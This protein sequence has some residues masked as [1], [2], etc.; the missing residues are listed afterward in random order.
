MHALAISYFKRYKMEIDLP[1]LSAP[2]FPPGF[3]PVAWRADLFETHVEILAGCFKGEL[4]TAV[5]PSLGSV[6][7]CRGLMAEIVRRRDFIP[8]STW[9]LVGPDGPCGTVQALRERGVLGAIQNVGVLPSYRGRGLAHALLLH[10]LHGMYQSGLGRAVLEVTAT[11]E[12]AVRLYWRMGFRRS[13]VV[14]KAV[15]AASSSQVRPEERPVL[16]A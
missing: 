14:Y 9:L 8:E 4:D 5:F 16:Y 2:S 15:P 7:G 1:G 12:S 11:N 6:E 10:A 13:K 3:L